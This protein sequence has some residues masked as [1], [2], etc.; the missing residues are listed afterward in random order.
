MIIGHMEATSY[1][2]LCAAYGTH[3]DK[4]PKG[5]IVLVLNTP[6]FIK[7]YVEVEI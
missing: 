6:H 4:I 3:N 7:T 1:S 2:F 5:K